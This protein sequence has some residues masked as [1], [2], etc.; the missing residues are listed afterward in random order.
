MTDTDTSPP[1]SA[2]S[3]TAI[4]DRLRAAPRVGAKARSLS[5][6]AL[7]VAATP[8]SAAEGRSDRAVREKD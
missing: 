2:S 1:I 3:A 5:P 6:E 7:A 4:L 8:A